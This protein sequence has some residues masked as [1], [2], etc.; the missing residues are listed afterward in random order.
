MGWQYFYGI[1]PV[2]HKKGGGT[3]NKVFGKDS[4]W[5]LVTKL[6]LTRMRV[7]HFAMELT[8]LFKVRKIDRSAEA[9]R[10]RHTR[11]IFP[12]KDNFAYNT[13]Q[14]IA[15]SKGKEWQKIKVNSNQVIRKEKRIDINPLYLFPNR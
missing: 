10:V 12:S 14:A 2:I 6:K 4:A 15:R 8:G 5:T 1:I 13:T 3:N 7:L 9:L 11:Q